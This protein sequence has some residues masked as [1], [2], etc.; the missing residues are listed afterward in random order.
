MNRRD[1]NTDTVMDTDRCEEATIRRKSNIVR[2]A[3][4][5]IERTGKWL[6]VSRIP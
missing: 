1:P 3:E 5:G 2:L 6:A 4:G